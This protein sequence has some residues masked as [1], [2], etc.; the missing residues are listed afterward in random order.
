MRRAAH[1]LAATAAGGGGQ[2]SSG[3]L[4]ALV[5][6]KDRQLQTLKQ[7]VH[8]PCAAHTPHRTRPH[9]VTHSLTHSLTHA[10]LFHPGYAQLRV[11]KDILVNEVKK[12]QADVARLGHENGKTPQP[13]RPNSLLG[14]LLIYMCARVGRVRVRVR[15]QTSKSWTCSTFDHRRRA[16]RRPPRARNTNSPPFSSR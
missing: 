16:F 5:H 7:G 6:E 13:T 15:S 14:W 1:L 3:Q 9:L 12:L 11:K 10:T 4:T 8:R 2:A